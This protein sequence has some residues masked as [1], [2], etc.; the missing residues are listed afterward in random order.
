MTMQYVRMSLA[1]SATTPQEVV[2]ATEDTPER[3]LTEMK[4]ALQVEKELT[5]DQI[6]ERYLNIA[7]FGNR[8]YGVFAASQVYFNKKPKDLTI[9]EAALLA[10]MVKAP[11]TFDPTTRAATPSPSTAAT[12]SSTDMVDIGAI[13]PA[14]AAAAKK[15]TLTVKGKRAPNG[16]VSV[17]QE[18]LGLLL[19]LLLPLV[20]GAGGVRRHAR[21]TGSGGS[22]AAATGSSPSLDIKAQDAAPK[23]ITEQISRH[24]QE[25]ACCWPRSSRAPARCG[26][27]PPTANTSWTT[28]PTR[29]TVSSDPAKAKKQIR[30]HLPEHHQPA[31]HRRWR[32]HRLPGRL[33]VQDVH[34][35]GGAG[36]GLSARLHDQ[37]GQAAVRLEL[38]HRLGQPGRPAPARTSGARSNSAPT[39][40]ASTTCGPASASR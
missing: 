15:V 38:H 22:R 21:T 10:G 30:G 2:A 11:T 24:E 25:R 26:R 20:D 23:Q 4:Y 16:C 8:A 35:G 36:E 13:T 5:K 34:H 27:S 31:A 1:Y 18:Q 19:R 37:R 33:G 17:S 29:R 7:P 6:L 9:A 12:T 3:K 14:Q 32:H 28:R 40:P 39:R